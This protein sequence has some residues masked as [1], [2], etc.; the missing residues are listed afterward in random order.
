MREIRSSVRYAFNR[1]VTKE[2]SEEQA[3]REISGLLDE[4]GRTGR[5]FQDIAQTATA[6]AG[7]VEE[8]KQL[9]W[10]VLKGVDSQFKEAHDRW[11][12]TMAR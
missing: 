11:T 1:V 2:I 8:R 12:E 6:W 9:V 10:R 5:I 4:K 3:A 7:D